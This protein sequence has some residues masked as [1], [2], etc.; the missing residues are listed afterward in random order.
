MQKNVFLSAKS[1]LRF[2]QSIS[3]L[4]SQLLKLCVP[5]SAPGKHAPGRSA[6]KAR[7][8]GATNAV[9]SLTE[10]REAARPAVR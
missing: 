5:N 2:P 1:F 7:A 4:C 9:L 3:Y 6:K 10:W 8:A